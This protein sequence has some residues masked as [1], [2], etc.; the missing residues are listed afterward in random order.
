MR[1]RNPATLEKDVLQLTWKKSQ[2]LYT[3]DVTTWKSGGVILTNDKVAPGSQL[4]VARAEK[5]D[6]KLRVFYQEKLN[7]SGKYPLREIQYS[8]DRQGI[9][10]WPVQ[11]AEILG[12]RENSYLSAVS[13]RRTGDIRLYYEGETGFLTESF[14]NKTAEKWEKSE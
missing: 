10:S 9:V 8:K 13:A 4:A 3:S 7:A 2:G 1:Y 6:S 12:A 14:W 5:D 11:T